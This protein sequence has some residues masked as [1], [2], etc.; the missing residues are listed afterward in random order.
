[1]KKLL[2][3]GGTRFVGRVLLSHLIQTNKYDITL[4]NRGLTNPDLYPQLKRICGDRKN[5]QDL[6]LIGSQ[7]W[8]CI[9]D[10]SGYWPKALED[11][12]EI[13]K[14]RIGRY[15]YVSTSSH[16]QFTPDK[17]HLIKEEE[18]TLDCSLEEKLN[19]DRSLYYN[20]KKAESERILKAQK[21]LN[22]IILRPGLI[23]GRYD[24]SDRLYYWFYKVKHQ[25]EVLVANGGKDIMS[26]TDVDDLA[27]IILHSIETEYSKKIYNIPSFNASIFDFI[28]LVKKKLNKEIKIHSASTEFLTQNNVSQWVGL[29]L[30]IDGNFLTTDST[31][32][33]ADYGFKF[34][35]IEQAVVDVLD[36]YSSIKKWKASEVESK[37]I[38]RE[39]ELN[40]IGK[41]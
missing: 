34:R 18:S 23:I 16:Y 41:L 21:D 3:L 7:D 24:Y 17:P 36:Y 19:D 20:Q 33:K 1:M 30:W 4:F 13:Q 25:N 28:D 2:V 8:D 37:R 11:Q 10:I 35:E 12:L 29:P 40:L 38:S 14:G 6:N 27:R 15:I 22:Y 32:V 5:I 39:I 26:Y 9:I 31:K